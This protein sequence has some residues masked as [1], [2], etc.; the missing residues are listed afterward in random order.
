LGFGELIQGGQDSIFGWS[1]RR[2]P[3]NMPDAM[4]DRP[5]EGSA[6]DANLSSR[7]NFL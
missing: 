1:S 3:A 2:E 6:I 5:F 4:S 7:H